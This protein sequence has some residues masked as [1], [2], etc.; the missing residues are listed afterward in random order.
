MLPNPIVNDVLIHETMDE[1]AKR[2]SIAFSE[3]LPANGYKWLKSVKK[4]TNKEDDQFTTEE[5]YS[6]FIKEISK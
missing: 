2:F 3:W 6:K 1:H 5:A 4:W